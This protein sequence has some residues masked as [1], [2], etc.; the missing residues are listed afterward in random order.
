MLHH[1][2]LGI[3]HLVLITTRYDNKSKCFRPPP[4]S[5]FSHHPPTT[6]HLPTPP[7]P[8]FIHLSH[9][10]PT[11]VKST[12]GHLV[13]ITL[14]SCL[15]TSCIHEGL[16][17]KQFST[18]TSLIVTPATTFFLSHRQFIWI[19]CWIEVCMSPT[20]IGQRAVKACVGCKNKAVNQMV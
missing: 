20:T 14:T 11:F 1:L 4:F 16:R 10:P 7:L 6:S 5:H 9:L 12:K 8:H 17:G 13:E 18:T 19:G 2:T 3:Y 15:Q